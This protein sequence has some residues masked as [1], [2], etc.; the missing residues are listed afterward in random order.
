M[1]KFKRKIFDTK[2]TLFRDKDWSEIFNYNSFRDEFR[3]D[4]IKETLEYSLIPY[5]YVPKEAEKLLYSADSIAILHAHGGVLNGKW[6][7]Q[8]TRLFGKKFIPVQ[9]WINKCDGKYDVLF[10]T[11]CGTKSES[12]INSKKSIV[13]HAKEN[14]SLDELKRHQIKMHVYIPGKGYL[15]SVEK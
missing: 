7:Y 12:K 15:S 11:A 9:D 13:V 3:G 4:N 6:V 10:T 8:D 5:H 14:F 1:K 2:V